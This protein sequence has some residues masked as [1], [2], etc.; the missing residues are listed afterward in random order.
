MRRVL[1]QTAAWAAATG[2]AV[3][4]SWYGVHRVLSVDGYQQPSTLA[5][6]VA[7]S[8]STTPAPLPS[9]AGSASQA[10]LPPATATHR[11]SPSH[12]PSA[13][14]SPGPT[15]DVH[16]YTPTGGRIVVSMGQSSADLV[17]ATPDSGWS[18]HVYTGDQWLRV[19]FTQGT[20]DSI[21]YVTWNGHAPMVQTWLTQ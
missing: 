1:V 3:G 18:M 4:V 6:N 8:V 7:G 17:S 20:T 15:G 13:S 16:S 19:D 5:L 10:P 12:S 9:T 21:F 11:P 14:A 2:A